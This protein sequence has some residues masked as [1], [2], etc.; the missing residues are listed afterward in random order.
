[1]RFLELVGRGFSI[2]AEGGMWYSEGV[3]DRE[4][5]ISGRKAQARIWK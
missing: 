2:L 5:Q 1:M 3:V 4:T